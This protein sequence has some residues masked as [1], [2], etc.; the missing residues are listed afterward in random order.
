MH[1]VLR[2]GVAACD[3]AWLAEQ[4]LAALVEERDLRRLDRE[5]RQVIGQAQVEQLADRV[6]QQVD[7]DAE[8][9]QLLRALDDGRSDSRGVQG[10]RG[11]ESADARTGDEDF[12]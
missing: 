3:A 6:R 4:Q 11:G 2:P 1:R 5:P 7:A 8:R 10:Q 12:R 9:L